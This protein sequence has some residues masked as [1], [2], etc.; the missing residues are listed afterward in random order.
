MSVPFFARG[1]DTIGK[2]IVYG[3][4]HEAHIVPPRNSGRS[5]PVQGHEVGDHIGCSRGVREEHQE[6]GMPMGR[7]KDE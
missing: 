1:H 7:L 5:G 3:R 2:E 4:A 6:T